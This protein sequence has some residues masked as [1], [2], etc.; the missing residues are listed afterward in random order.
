MGILFSFHFTKAETIT[1]LTCI[2][3][4]ALPSFPCPADPR[5][6]LGAA[7]LP[8]DALACGARK[9]CRNSTQTNSQ[10]SKHSLACFQQHLKAL[11]FLKQRLDVSKALGYKEKCL[12]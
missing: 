10:R 6:G 5:Y 4:F 9:L 3:L 11:F 12:M 7:P 2:L 1:H 8:R